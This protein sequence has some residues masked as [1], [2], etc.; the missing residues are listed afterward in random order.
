MRLAQR[1]EAWFNQDAEP[2]ILGGQAGFWGLAAPGYGKTPILQF[3]E[4]AG[5]E[6]REPGLQQIGE[7]QSGFDGLGLD[8]DEADV[9]RGDVEELGRGQ[10]VREPYVVQGVFEDEEGG[11]L[12]VLQ[13]ADVAGLPLEIDCIDDEQ[14]VAALDKRQQVQAGG[15]TVHDFQ[16][17]GRLTVGFE[18]TDGMD[19]HTF[20]P[21][22]KVTKADQGYLRSQK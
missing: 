13:D 5:Q 9:W 20:I 15:A 3:G 2:Q 16:A 21:Q 11:N 1:T 17:V 12:L 7:F 14:P 18:G 4:D 22:E 6:L 10:D 19:A 8:T